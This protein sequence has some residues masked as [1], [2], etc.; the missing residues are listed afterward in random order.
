MRFVYTFLIS[1]YYLGVLIAS[2]FHEKARKWIRGRKGLFRTLRN[3]MENGG[4][5][6][7]VHCASLG[8]FE[9]GRP[10]IESLRKERPGWKILLTFFSPSGYEVRKNYAGADLVTYLPFDFPW[11]A[12]KFL[13]LLRPRMAVFVKYEFW[14]HYLSLLHRRNIPLAGISVIIRE[15]HPFLSWYGRPYR[16]VLQYFNHLFVQDEDSA[17]RLASIGMDRVTVS[18]D[19]R[20]DRV[21]DIAAS[22]KDLDIAA[23]FSAGATVLVAGSTWPADEDLLLRYLN[24]NTGRDLKCILVPHEIGEGHISRIMDQVKQQAIRYSMAGGKDLGS[25]RILVVDNVG[26]LSSIYR[27][28][29]I[30]YIGGGFG[31]GIHNILEAAVY[32]IP[33]LF[34]PN[35]KKFREAVQLSELGAAFPVQDYAQLEERLSRLVNDKEIREKCGVRASSY[36]KKSTGAT[37]AIVRKLLTFSS[38]S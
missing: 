24:G 14:Y 20:F 32:G 36:I 12:R 31:K 25:I 38:Q 3:G 19:T 28:G 13:D 15:N 18:G 26:M 34:G 7:W 9:Q 37:P 16:K 21:V 4:P 5:W 17:G 35:Y 33:V 1:L 27:Y 22:A 30:A 8:E 23:G 29:Q 6:I 11:N 10:V 2:P